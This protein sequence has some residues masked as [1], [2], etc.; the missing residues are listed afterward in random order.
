[1]ISLK[2]VFTSLSSRAELEM[3]FSSPSLPLGLRI[4]RVCPSS[5]IAAIAGWSGYGRAAGQTNV[6]RYSLTAACQNL[7]PVPTA[8]LMT[9]VFIVAKGRGPATAAVTVA[10]G[11]HLLKQTERGAVAL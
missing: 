9:G 11:A 3:R 4:F 1:M 8:D 10:T 2:T 7:L 6:C 5:A